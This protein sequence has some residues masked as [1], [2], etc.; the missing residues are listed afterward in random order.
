MERTCDDG[1]RD[2]MRLTVSTPPLPRRA[3]LLVA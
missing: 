1:A 3:E 2:L